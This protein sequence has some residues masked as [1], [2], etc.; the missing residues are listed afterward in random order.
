MISLNRQRRRLTLRVSNTQCIWT[1]LIGSSIIYFYTFLQFTLRLDSDKQLTRK[2]KSSSS[3]IS[4]TALDHD[5]IL[6]LPKVYEKASGGDDDDDDGSGK[7]RPYPFKVVSNCPRNDIVDGIDSIRH[8]RANTNDHIISIRGERHTG[9]KLTR[10]LLNR[11]MKGVQQLNDK[12]A[13]VNMTM[14]TI[15]G[16]KHGFFPSNLVIHPLDLFLIITRDPFSWALSMF[17]DPYNMIFQENTTNFG[18]FLMGSYTSQNCEAP[19]FMKKCFFPMEEAPNIIQV[20]ILP[21]ISFACSIYND[22]SI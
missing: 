2:H 5:T 4:S 20:N 6:E 21:M 14:D 19:H 18:P 9:T 8:H 10:L 3:V 22:M 13:D 17:R 1:L 16:W 12:L 11:N 7:H 15:Y